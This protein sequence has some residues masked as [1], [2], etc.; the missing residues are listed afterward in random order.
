MQN[1]GQV[2][3]RDGVTVRLGLVGA[4]HYLKASWPVRYGP[5]HE[6]RTPGYLFQ[7][8]PEGVIRFIQGRPGTWHDHSDWFKRSPGGDWVYYASGGYNGAVSS[9]GEHYVPLFPYPTNN[10]VGEKRYPSE[11]L[12]NGLDALETLLGRVDALAGGAPPMVARFL[13]CL[14]QKNSPEMLAGLAS[15][16]HGLVQGPLSVLPPDS[17]HV[18]YDVLPVNLAR[19]CLYHCRFCGVKSPKPFAV[20]EP[21]HVACQVAALRQF[22]KGDLAN[23]GGIFLG[24][25]DALA[26]GVE[27]V[28][29]AAGACLPLLNDVASMA[30]RPALFL[31]GSPDALVSV[32]DAGWKAL[33]R[34]P[35]KVWINTGIESLD[36]GT[37]DHLGRPTSLPL[38]TE[39][40]RRADEVVRRH[41]NISISL[42]MVIGAGLPAAHDLSLT[43]FVAS[44]NAQSAPIYLSPLKGETSRQS[45]M[46]GFIDLKRISRAPLFLYLLQRL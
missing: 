20:E 32:P 36:E 38:I 40:V 28:V 15:R 19:G 21:N 23:M 11:K 10:V 22:F 44:R 37:L 24:E 46:H 13:E 1:R 2:F 41:G 45:A 17:R 35:F 7:F 14:R 18:D 34:L 5:F 43:R 31:F 4:V 39:A 30:D 12:R 6:I 33:D 29:E 8:S 26:A 25:H 9:M 3:S 42:N 27:R 16:F